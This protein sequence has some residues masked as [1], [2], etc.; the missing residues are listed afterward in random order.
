[1]AATTVNSADH[2]EPLKLRGIKGK[3]DRHLVER[4]VPPWS[5]IGRVNRRTGGFCSGTLIAPKR[6]LTAAHCLWNPRTR[7]WLPPV[8]LHFVSGYSKGEF[9]AHARIVEFQ[10]SPDYQPARSVQ[11][12]LSADWAILTLDKTIAELVGV[13]PLGNMKP[14]RKITQAGYSKDKP[15]ILTLNK[16]CNILQHDNQRGLILHDC[17][18]TKGDSGA[19][20]LQWHN[21][22]FELIGIHVA[23]RGRGD[24]TQGVAVLNSAK[25]GWR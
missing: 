8:S 18:A 17:D 24:T 5:A 2:R 20:I 12:N 11:K 19:P 13:I 4:V 9:I 3:D 22:R 7:N 16:T 1:M 21:N 15:H 6:V 14:E 10:V 23:T 25:M